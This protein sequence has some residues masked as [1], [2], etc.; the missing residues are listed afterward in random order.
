M[1]INENTLAKDIALL[2]GN[3]QSLSIAQ[4]KE[5]IRLTLDCLAKHRMSDVVKLIEKHGE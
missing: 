2:E 3:S 5:V 1:A 4:V